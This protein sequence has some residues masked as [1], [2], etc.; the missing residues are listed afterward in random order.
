MLIHCRW[1][2]TYRS[3]LGLTLIPP[4]SCSTVACTSTPAT[5]TRSCFRDDAYCGVLWLQAI[6]H[7]RVLLL[8]APRPN[9][10][11]FLPVERA[12]P[13][14]PTTSPP[15]WMSIACSFPRR[16]CSTATTTIV[17][18]L[19]VAAVLRSCG[20]LPEARQSHVELP[21]SSRS[22]GFPGS[23][24]WRPISIAVRVVGSGER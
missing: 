12:F 20:R 5:P 11:N 8:H 7:Q 23:S 10:Q 18:Q 19:G 14:H 16:S 4:A 1:R 6:K 3:G 9:L 13:Q 24:R 15:P 22:V 17:A 21:Q 2:A